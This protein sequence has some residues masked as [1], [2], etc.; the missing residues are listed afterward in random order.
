[1][2]KMYTVLI[3]LLSFWM[4]FT[5]Q[6]W[7]DS[8]ISITFRY[9]DP[10][11]QIVRVFLPGEFN[12]WN[13]DFD[14]SSGPSIMT[15]DKSSGFWIKQVQLQVGS[16]YAYKFYF[17]LDQIVS[18]D[19]WI[20]DPLNQT[21]DGSIYGNSLLTITDPMIFQP[22]QKRGVDGAI[23]NITAGIFGSVPFMEMWLIIDSDSINVLTSFDPST[24]ILDHLL[25]EGVSETM[26]I[27]IRG[28]DNLGRV[29][30]YEYPS[31]QAGQ[32]KI[33]ATF[34]FH[35]NQNL[36]PAGK[37]ASLACF[38]GLLETLRRHPLLKFQLHFSGTLLHDLLWFDDTAI[39]IIR[40][41]I[42]SGQFEIVG[43]T[44]V[45][46]IMYS[47]RSY[48][49]DF[50]FNDQQIKIHKKLI[51][52]IFDTT[53]RAFW[54][55]ER[56]WTQNFV[57]LL[58]DNG[59]EYVQIEGYILEESGTTNDVDVVRTTT[60][61][62]RQ[63]VVFNDNQEFLGR[64]DYAVDEGHIH[65]VLDYLHEKYDED[66]NDQFVIGYYQD[67]EATGLWDYEWG[68]HPQANWN[69]LDNLL[70]AIE[71]DPLVKVT[72]YAEFLQSNTPTEELTPIVDGA[73]S[74][75]GRDEWFEENNHPNFQ[76][77]RELYDD[78]RNKLNHVSELIQT[79]G[80]D[81]TSAT[82][83]LE[84]AWFTLA[85][86]QFEFAVHGYTHAHEYTQWQLARTAHVSALAATHA[87]YP[88]TLIYRADVNQDEID[89]YVMVDPQDLYVFSYYGGRLLYWF[90]LEKGEEL[91]G[92]EN[93]MVDYNEIYVDDSKYVPI[94]RG[95][96]D[97]YWWLWGNSVFPEVFEWEFTIRRRALNDWITV[98]TEKSRLL[99]YELYLGSMDTQSLTFR[100]SEDNFEIRKTVTP[101]EGGLSVTYILLSR[102]ANDIDVALE[103][104][105]GFCPSY[106][107]VMD[108]GRDALAYWDGT[109][110]SQSVSESTIGVINTV[111]GSVIHY[112]FNTPPAYL[113]GE[114]NVFGLELNP[115][116]DL[117]IVPGDSITLNFSMRKTGFVASKGDV[118]GDGMVDIID[119]VH[120]VN[121]IL[122][123]NTPTPQ[124]SWAAD[125][126]NDSFVNI[127]DV[128]CIVN[129]ILE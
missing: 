50:Q 53:P 35:A 86:H 52:H 43:S 16:S 49:T 29:V 58:D 24:G 6:S 30:T 48:S 39:Q 78:I 56:V 13:T 88:T 79:Y 116:F 21:Y 103:I 104:E 124:E 107:D 31:I 46:N 80:G 8:D 11:G 44:Y 61:D 129:I 41:G 102:A 1:M 106:M 91:I 67:A 123:L 68:Q 127:L 34:L 99:A 47:T 109:N 32:R 19:Q 73:A 4:F 81:T 94:V 118:N 119:V 65:N 90:D 26:P 22:T 7:G 111:T 23:E 110:T 87:L 55:C 54:N 45:Q 72:T 128:V 69:N 66:V 89:E 25:A 17:H 112:D 83:L 95:G 93:F 63:I 96:L 40:E 76:A 38:V 64:V 98:N 75:M 18:Q 9:K 28:K 27:R 71:N 108:N 114:E 10:P 101:I 117:T 113:T 92:N 12:D 126:N 5:N 82:K 59:Y 20:P 121:F 115:V 62:N 37:V 125:C 120:V 85:A 122:S 77:M 33:D 97:T 3:I 42:D 36:V 14:G 2:K 74:W 70:T 60:Y 15:Y 84:H 105:C 57:Q 51:E 100:Y